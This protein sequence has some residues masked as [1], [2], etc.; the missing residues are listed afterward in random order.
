MSV[1]VDTSVWSLVLRR[2]GPKNNAHAKELEKLVVESEAQIIGPIRQ[3]IL[4]GIREQKQFDKLKNSLRAFED[5][6]LTTQHYEQAAVFFNICRSNG[7]QGSITDFLICSVAVE[8]NLS[9][10][11]TDQDFTVY[12]AHLPIKLH[13]F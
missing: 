10:F 1:L 11:T 2:K 8:A 4:S 13:A 7:V 5:L 3:E 6:P 12:Q 9:V